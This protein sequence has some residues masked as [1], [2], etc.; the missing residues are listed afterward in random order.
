[1]IHTGMG[2]EYSDLQIYSDFTW[3]RI[4]HNVRKRFITTLIFIPTWKNVTFHCTRPQLSFLMSS[5]EELLQSQLLLDEHTD[6]RVF[7][8]YL[9]FLMIVDHYYIDDNPTSS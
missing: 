6:T 8:Y 7:Q 9:D 4:I 2:L 5:Y 1:M 3:G